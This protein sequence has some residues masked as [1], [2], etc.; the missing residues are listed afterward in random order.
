MVF[1]KAGAPANAASHLACVRALTRLDE[2]DKVSVEVE[3]PQFVETIKSPHSEDEEHVQYFQ[4]KLVYPFK[5]F[6]RRMNTF[7]F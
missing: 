7:K 4:G 2:G 3:G 6:K 5:K 1:G